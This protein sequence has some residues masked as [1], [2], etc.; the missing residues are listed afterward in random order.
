[1]AGV[2]WSYPPDDVERPAYVFFEVLCKTRHCLS[3]TPDGA[4]DVRPWMALTHFLVRLCANVGMGL[5]EFREA[6]D[7]TYRISQLG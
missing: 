6:T 7:S 4:R 1:M 5:K 2:A 3:R